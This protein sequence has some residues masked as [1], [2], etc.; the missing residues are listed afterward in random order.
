MNSNKLDE[1]SV[2]LSDLNIKTTLDRIKRNIDVPI[3]KEEV[4][5]YIKNHHPSKIQMQLVYAYYAKY[6][7]SYRDLNVLTRRDY[8]TLLVLLKKK[9]L[10]ELGYENDENGTIYYASLPYILT[11]NLEDRLNTRIIRNN[12]FL[13]KIDDNYMYEN[14]IN[15]K[16][17]LM[18]SINPEGLL[19]L[20]S[21]ILNSKFT[22]VVYEYPELLGQPIEYSDDKTTD[23]LLFFLNSI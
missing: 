11:G 12:K 21:T 3:S 19:T 10:L 18:E 1:G 17:R 9:L 8:M 20:I 2:I 14:L 13:N 6:F 22:Y 5:Y 4:D 7:G 23:E 16:Y 15:N